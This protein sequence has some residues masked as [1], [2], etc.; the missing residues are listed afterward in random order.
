[1]TKNEYLSILKVELKRNNAA[2]SEDIIEEYEQHFAFKLAD[3]FSEE[4]VSAK[5]GSPE[6]VAKQ[7]KGEKS[8]SKAASNG[9]GFVVIAMMLVAIVE[10]IIYILFF[11]WAISVFATALASAGIGFALII[12][13]NPSGLIPYLP[14]SSALIFGVCFLALAVFLAAGSYYFFSYARQIVRASIRWHKNVLSGNALPPLP[15][16]PQF[17]AK[18][19]RKLRAILLWSVTVFGSTMILGMV[20]SQIISG[21]LGFWHAWNWFV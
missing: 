20:V 16:S 6:E 9:N 19:K 7:F 21:S 18:T 2:E 8:E 12:G 4:E 10:A 1:M 15:W 5:L 13:L 3:G 14:Y 17:A 11:A